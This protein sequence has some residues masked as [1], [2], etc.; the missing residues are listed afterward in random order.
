MYKLDVGSRTVSR[1]FGNFKGYT[2]L[3]EKNKCRSER[4]GVLKY[5][6]STANLSEI[7]CCA[8]PDQRSPWQ[9]H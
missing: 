9:E 8:N 3:V 4:V 5:D 1:G 2:I 7:Y 6:Y